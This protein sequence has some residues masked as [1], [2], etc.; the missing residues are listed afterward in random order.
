MDPED[1]FTPWQYPTAYLEEN[2]CRT[3]DV[4]FRQ[5]IKSREGP[6]GS[7][8]CYVESDTPGVAVMEECDVPVCSQC[9]A[10]NVT[11]SAGNV[12]G[13]DSNGGDGDDVANRNATGGNSNGG[14]RTLPIV[15]AIAGAAILL[16]LALLAVPKVRHGAQAALCGVRSNQRQPEAARG[17]IQSEV[18]SQSTAAD[19]Q[20]LLRAYWSVTGGGS[21]SEDR[22]AA[23]HSRLTISGWLELFATETDEAS[24]QQAASAGSKSLSASPF[25]LV[26]DLEENRERNGYHFLRQLGEGMQA[27][28]YL[29][30]HIESG[31]LF[32]AKKP[33]KKESCKMFL[34]ESFFLQLLEGNP[35]V[36]SVEEMF[37]HDNA[38][39]IIMEYCSGGTMQDYLDQLNA[40]ERRLPADVAHSWLTQLILGVAAMHECKVLHRDIKPENIMLVNSE[41]EH[42]TLR[43]GDFGSS[44][45]VLDNTKTFIGTPVFMAPEVLNFEPYSMSADVWSI[46]C[47]LYVAC[48]GSLPFTQDAS[49]LKTLE[50]LRQLREEGDLIPIPEE[51]YGQEFV[52]IVHS[53]LDQDAKQ[54]PELMELIKTNKWLTKR[55]KRIVYANNTTPEVDVRIHDSTL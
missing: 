32:A 6:T 5:P 35:L 47:T 18:E 24:V 55:V 10:G 16:T 30:E 20:D 2:F 28:V 17:R 54:R 48:M 1:D 26:M 49:L 38:M 53:M 44:K 9:S 31:R 29:V 36:V 4:D 3:P 25:R 52:E 50:L 22:I 33:R 11:G 37:V 39:Y 21:Y 8:W 45:L 27:D 46:G 23:I 13:S 43:I 51:I 12:T 19:G 40:E 7:P 34:S 15:G 14:I 41:D 42:N